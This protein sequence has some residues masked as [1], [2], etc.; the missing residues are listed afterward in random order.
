MRCKKKEGPGKPLFSGADELWG[1][2]KTDAT[3]SSIQS[4]LTVWI[5]RK[6]IAFLAFRLAAP[7]LAGPFR[8]AFHYH[9]VNVDF[10]NIMY[11]IMQQ[12]CGGSLICCT[13]VLQPK[14]HRTIA[15]STPWRNEFCFW[16]ITHCHH[17]LVITRESIHE[18]KHGMSCC[19]VY[20]Q[21]NVRERLRS[22]LWSRCRPLWVQPQC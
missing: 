13:G 14:W 9:V 22:N 2:G 17:Y 12:S 16:H 19:V 15:E 6:I 21:I 10:H 7:V 3:R 4:R 20:Q 8:L 11:Q 5:E 18:W 1:L